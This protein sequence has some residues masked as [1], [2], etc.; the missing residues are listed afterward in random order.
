MEKFLRWLLTN[1]QKPYMYNFSLAWPTLF[2]GGRDSTLDEGQDPFQ[3][4]D[5][6]NRVKTH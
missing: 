4:Q 2:L 5:N 1:K 3:S 6:N